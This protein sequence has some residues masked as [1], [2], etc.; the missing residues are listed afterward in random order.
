MLLLHTGEIATALSICFRLII[1]ES[2]FPISW[3]N[4]SG[5]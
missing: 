5:A 2:A 4:I 1:D 3:G